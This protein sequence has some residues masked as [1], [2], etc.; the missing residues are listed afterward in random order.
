M[1]EHL[2]ETML[3]NKGEE[4]LSMFRG[5]LRGIIHLNSKGPDQPVHPSIPN[6][7]HLSFTALMVYLFVPYM[8]YASMS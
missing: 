8:K 6:S 4:V 2:L 1:L 3:E 7:V 5:K